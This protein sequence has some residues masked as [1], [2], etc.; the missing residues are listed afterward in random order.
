MCGRNLLASS[1]EQILFKDR[2]SRYLAVS[3]GWLAGTARRRLLENVI[4]RTD[5]E[6]FGEAR[7]SEA[8]ADELCVIETGEP[9]LAKLEHET[10]DDG[11]DTWTQTTK[12]ALRDNEG[13]I[14]GTW[15]VGRDVTSSVE[16]ARA[17]DAS[18]ESLRASEELGSVLFEHNPQ[19][20]WI[21]DQVT[22]RVLAVNMAALAMYG[23]SHDEFLELTVTDLVP[24]ADA[25]AFLR[26]L[27]QLE[28]ESRRAGLPVVVPRR[29]RCKDGGII[30]VE[31]TSTDVSLAG[32]PCRIASSKDVTARNRAAAE[33]AA[34]RDE[35]IEA[36]NMKSAFLATISHE[37]RTPMNGVLGMTELLLDSEL[38]DDQ[39]ALAKQVSRSGELMVELIDD[40]LD[41][42][43]IETGRLEL[44][45]A[46]FPL[47]ETIEQS[48]APVRL[49]AD[50]KGVA[51][52]VQIADDVP[53]QAR[54]D[55]RRLRQVLLNLVANA[56]K[57]TAAGS[58]VVRVSLLPGA[59]GDRQIR[60]E[61]ADTGIGIE[62]SILGEVFEP[63]TQA[64]ASTT[65]IYGGTGL[66]LTIARELVTLM[67][68]AIGA[69]SEPGVG[70]TFWIEIPL[71]LAR[72]NEG[73]PCGASA[74]RV[75]TRPL[76]DTPP[77]VLV[78]EDSPVNQ[79]VTVRTLERCGCRVD[80]VS[81]GRQALD[82][83]AKQRY[84]AVLMDCEMLEMDGYNATAELRL[85]EYGTR[86]T[87]VIA[88]TAHALPDDRARCLAAGM[89]DYVS[90]P[91]R[92]E[93]LIDTLRRWIPPH[94]DAS[95]PHDASPAAA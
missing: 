73:R 79:I 50:A 13:N 52:K 38:D 12:A 62:P 59:N 39:R 92:R 37:L 93:Q 63:F 3:A 43:K 11:P 21:R 4:G 7:G 86:H 36:S 80:V 67:C 54:G 66:G 17:L 55:G 25:E 35:A 88:M 84:D 76:W 77:S 78:A 95:V 40:I 57:F 70:S 2:E 9:M 51:L 6:V 8:R 46:D 72:S 53:E 61:V 82:A 24:P 23:Y 18:Q 10:V 83:L 71:A 42:S 15:G 27:G 81:D 5:V 64:D 41:I 94:S 74:T 49:Q 56:V 48:C 85:R 87:P 47:R 44:A 19:P 28:G 75:A 90:K 65:R 45:I 14:V 33:L 20:M 31:L 68:G 22:L 58:V 34:A 16:S 26:S 32:R 29:H 30:E 91:I 69:E 89:D 60:V 1:D